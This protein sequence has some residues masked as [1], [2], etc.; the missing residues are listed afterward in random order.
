MLK[1]LDLWNITKTLSYRPK[2]SLYVENDLAPM[3]FSQ[4]QIWE[5]FRNVSEIFDFFLNKE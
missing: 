4:P 5:K 3:N 2:A 1:T